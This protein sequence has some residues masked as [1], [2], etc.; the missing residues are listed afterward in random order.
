MKQYLAVIR[1]AKNAVVRFAH[2]SCIDDSK[3]ANIAI[4]LR[5]NSTGNGILENERVNNYT[6]PFRCAVG[7]K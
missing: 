2:F 5:D 1:D 4:G 7:Q 3:A 6:R